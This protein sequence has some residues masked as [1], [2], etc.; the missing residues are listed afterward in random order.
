[1]ASRKNSS[2]GNF[3]AFRGLQNARGLD[4]V[5]FGAFFETENT[6]ITRSN[7]PVRRPG[8]TRIFSGEV[9][10]IWGD[11]TVSLFLTASGELRQLFSDATSAVLRS[12]VTGA[13]RLA[14]VRVAN[15]VYWAYGTHR[16]V[17]EEGR[18]RPFG[19]DQVF[20]AGVVEL[21]ASQ[22]LAA[23][24]YR[25]AWA[26][27]T[28][29]G[30]EGPIG[31]RG[32]FELTDRGGVELVPPIPVDPRATRVRAFLTEVD[33]TN[34][35]RLGEVDAPTNTTEQ[36]QRR[37]EAMPLLQ[38]VRPQ[39]EDL[40]R[41]PPFADAHIYN[42]RLVVAYQNFVLFSERFDYE[43]FNPAE[44]FIPFS[45]R[46]N[47]VAP[48]KGGVFVGTDTDHFFL[49]GDDLVGAALDHKADYGAVPRTVDYLEQKE[50]GFEVAG[51]VAVWTG[52]RGPVFGLPGG[53]MEDTGDGVISFPSN[54][55]HGAG[56]VRK[57][58]GDV[59]YVSVIR[60][61]E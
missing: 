30:E 2:R 61:S 43:Y 17:L 41:L 5:E 32:A 16:G 26:V 49:R 55:V 44:M 56:A 19:L 4:Q 51:R 39:R 27:V 57:H 50:H 40:E 10:D 12:G 22:R 15:T 6:D 21:P 42:G 60:H 53:Q 48:V 28:G 45:S 38:A 8:R 31:I 37:I 54:V 3:T 23:G 7:K 36:G 52:H 34:L 25:Y 46:V 29:N 58:N 11:G 33:G 35:F 14:A 20:P 13:G 9:L 24:T 1:M 18:D 59:H 47:I